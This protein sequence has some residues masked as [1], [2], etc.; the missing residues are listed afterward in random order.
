MP[1][2]QP[3]P[4]LLDL[5]FGE[6]ALASL[7]TASP[8][9]LLWAAAFQ[10]WL[11][12]I[13]SRNVDLYKASLLGWKRLLQLS[14]L[15]PWA[16]TQ[17]HLFEFRQWLEGQGLATSSVAKNLFV[18][19]SFYRWSG[20]HLHDPQVPS[21]FNPAL[22]VPRP[23][24]KPYQSSTMLT[25][26]EARALLTLLEQ[27][28]WLLSRRDYAFFLSRL[29]LGVPLPLL[30]RLRW[31]QIQHRPDGAW[32]DWGAGKVPTRLPDPVWN[33]I[34]RYL[35][36]SGRLDPRF[37]AGMPPHSYIFAPQV[38]VLQ[39]EP[40]GLASDWD[41][42]RYLH[43]T[44]LARPLKTYGRLAGI[45]DH[46]LVMPA[47]RYTAAA[48]YLETNPTLAEMD[49]FL[50]S[51]GL[52][53]TKIFLHFL[54]RI[55]ERTVE[56]EYHPPQPTSLPARKPFRGEPGTAITHGY[57]AIIQPPQ[58]VAGLIAQDIHG[59][60]HELQGLQMLMDRLME[61]QEQAHPSALAAP[62]MKAYLQSA[63]CLSQLS[64]IDLP[65]TGPH[66]DD[67]DIL[68]CIQRFK[69]MTNDPIPLDIEGFQ[70]L[71]V[72]FNAGGNAAIS[73]CDQAIAGV[74]LVC[75]RLVTM[76]LAEQDDHQLAHLSELYCSACL[77][78]SRLLKQHGQQGRLRPLFDYL[79][80][81][82]IRWNHQR[83]AEER[84][85][86]PRSPS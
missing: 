30:Q 66:Q 3:L 40:T 10:D 70:Q 48:S 43:K 59:L 86:P 5:L 25:R 26:S 11:M 68:E 34:Q 36:A 18:I 84:L 7:H 52:S 64:S 53:N 22:A 56:D 65:E 31:G 1:T 74:R 29:N 79:V 54:K 38:D 55:Q 19:H 78:L 8:R 76:A 42:N 58:Q 9:L 14:R 2:D 63:S 35:H 85:A 73:Q 4:H 17:A 32:V 13:K 57:Y 83:M 41:E 45:P 77:R 75:K 44:S 50:G 21:G 46:K 81:E 27:D 71:A 24:F 51:P 72:E 47:L 20:R 61:R 82:A 16:I 28:Q 23:R 60:D 67:Q 12:D 6:A 69:E 39:K 37:P 49:A 62:L 80:E 33:A 15:P